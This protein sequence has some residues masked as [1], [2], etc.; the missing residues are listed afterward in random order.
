V[1][2][3]NAFLFLKVQNHHNTNNKA[4]CWRTCSLS[5]CRFCRSPSTT[6][7][8][9]P[10]G[11]IELSTPGPPCCTSAHI[12]IVLPNHGRRR[13][14]M[15]RGRRRRRRREGGEKERRSG[16]PHFN[17]NSQLKIGTH[18]HSGGYSGGYSGGCVALASP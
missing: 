7:S 3:I 16:D 5:A 11:T 8:T 13:R 17:D 9:A 6:A 4:G 15:G 14:G 10:Y 2:L 1:F 12:A 18:T